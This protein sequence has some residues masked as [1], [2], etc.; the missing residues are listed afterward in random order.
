MADLDKV[1]GRCDRFHWRTCV[2]VHPVQGLPPALQE[3]ESLQQDHRCPGHASRDSEATT[4]RDPGGEKPGRETSSSARTSVSDSELN[5]S[6]TILEP[7]RA[8]V[9]SVEDARSH[10]ETQ[11]ALRGISLATALRGNQVETTTSSSQLSVATISRLL[12]Q[13]EGGSVGGITTV[14]TV[15][16]FTD[17]ELGRAGRR[18]SQGGPRGRSGLTEPLLICDLP[19][20]NIATNP[21]LRGENQVTDSLASGRESSSPLSSSR[22]PSASLEFESGGVGPRDSSL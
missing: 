19:G 18:S 2:H 1:G 5:L 7:S 21:S 22:P 13:M 16:F 14:P 11:T 8:Q 9:S 20:Q 3:M 15:I 6:E 17:S 12:E 10:A 4:T